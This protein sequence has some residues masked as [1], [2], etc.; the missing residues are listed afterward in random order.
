MNFYNTMS[1]V[2]A[3]LM[4]P[5]LAYK[6]LK[7]KIT[8]NMASFALWCLLDLEAALSVFFQ[9]G[10]WYLPGA[11]VLGSLIVV[12]SLLKTRTWAWGNFETVI[13]FMVALCLGVWVTAGPRWA[14]IISTT[15]VVLAGLPQLKDV[16]L[17]PAEAPLMEYLGFTLAA[18]FGTMGGKSWTI[19]ERLYP[20]ACIGICGAVLLACLRRFF[21]PKPADVLDMDFDLP[22]SG[23][24]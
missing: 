13:L 11:Y 21:A 14:T 12:L 15:G 23:C 10:N 6:I 7:G 2:I 24:S 8:Q 3:L 19:E 1:V 4:Y 18:V 5:P 9:G 22:R 17:F 16:V 20:V